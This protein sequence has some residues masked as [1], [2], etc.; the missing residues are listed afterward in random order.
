M[1][2]EENEKKNEKK[3]DDDDDYE[4]NESRVKIVQNNSLYIFLIY[5]FPS[6]IC[7]SLDQSILDTS[8]TRVDNRRRQI[9]DNHRLCAIG[10]IGRLTTID[11]LT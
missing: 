1:Q 10:F 4:E 5:F 9:I 7:A 2:R 8:T 6:K 11:A 3:E